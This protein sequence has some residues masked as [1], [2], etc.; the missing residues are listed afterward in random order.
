M[1]SPMSMDTARAESNGSW[2]LTGGRGD[3]GSIGFGQCGGRMAQSAVAIGFPDAVA[4]ARR[5][6]P[7]WTL[8]EHTAKTR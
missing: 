1:D 2:L 8:F 5:L 6:S 3:G 4:C 7:S